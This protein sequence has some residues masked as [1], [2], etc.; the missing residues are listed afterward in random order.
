MKLAYLS[1]L[2]IGLI[3]TTSACTSH[4]F[5]SASELSSKDFRQRVEGEKTY[6]YS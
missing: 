1:L 3:L 2:V 6:L 4:R 5:T